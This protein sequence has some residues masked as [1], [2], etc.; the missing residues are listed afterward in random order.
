MHM[1]IPVVCT[2]TGGNNELIIDGQTGY[3]IRVGDYKML[4]EKLS[5]LLED[6]VR[7][8]RMAERAYERIT[9]LCSME[10]MLTQHMALYSELGSPRL[11][12]HT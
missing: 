7:A 12:Q 2:D 10:K 6:P 9:Q 1:Y 4:S 8:S 3:L 5:Q 11:A